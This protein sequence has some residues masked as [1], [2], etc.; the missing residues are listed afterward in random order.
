MN[1]NEKDKLA[2]GLAWKY[3]LGI[4]GINEAMIRDHIDASDYNS[5]KSIPE[6]FFRLCASAQNR[7]MAPSVIGKAIGGV[8]KLK[9]VTDDF[10]PQNVIAKY[11][12]NHKKLL[13]DIIKIL[14]P[15]GKVQRGERGLWPLYCKAILSIAAFLSQFESVESFLSWV[16]FFDKD[17]RARP[18][19][20]M[21][22]S[23]EIEGIGFALA[24]DFLKEMGYLNFGKPDVHLKKIFMALSLCSDDSD[25]TIF[26][27]ICRIARN[28]NQTPYHVDKL[29]WLIG[30]GYFYKNKIRVGRHRDKFIEFVKRATTVQTS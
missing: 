19:L 15:K 2:Y 30:S 17:E 21:L 16:D 3:L 25:Y 18:A 4:D 12:D 10:N 22:I 8:N 23:N 29:F 11:G 6:V 24:C 9:N 1:Q 26:K 13:D 27:T 5:P 28:V 7:N 20:P 14:N